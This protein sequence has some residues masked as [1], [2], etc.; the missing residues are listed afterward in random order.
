[1]M[2]SLW[3]KQTPLRAKKLSEKMRLAKWFGVY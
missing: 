1:M 3:A 2:D